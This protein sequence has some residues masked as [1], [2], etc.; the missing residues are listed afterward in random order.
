MK[1]SMDFHFRSELGHFIEIPIIYN[2]SRPNL[3]RARRHPTR[4]YPE[5]AWDFDNVE[6]TFPKGHM[7]HHSIILPEYGTI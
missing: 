3:S 1:F 4:V 6:L 7:A 2:T 5:N